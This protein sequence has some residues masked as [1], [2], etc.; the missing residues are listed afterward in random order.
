M[1]TS[2]DLSLIDGTEIKASLVMSVICLTVTFGG[3]Q[4]V[5]PYKTSA[6][7]AT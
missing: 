3:G 1:N 4:Y 6:T 5:D 2:A 7:P